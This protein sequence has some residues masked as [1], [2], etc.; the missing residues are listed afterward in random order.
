MLLKLYAFN[1]FSC[2]CF[3]RLSDERTYVEKRN[4]I[5]KMGFGGMVDSM[6][7]LTAISAI[8]LNGF[9]EVTSDIPHLIAQLNSISLDI[10][11]CCVSTQ[12]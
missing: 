11:F 5:N 3:F 7:L 4:G 1:Y 9:F 2:K 10:S 12:I 8:D 6:A